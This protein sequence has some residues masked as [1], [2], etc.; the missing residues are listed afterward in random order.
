MYTV[1]KRQHIW[2][3]NTH[4]DFTKIFSNSEYAPKFYSG[5][6]MWGLFRNMAPSHS[7]QPNYIQDLR[8]KPA[9]TW[10]VAPDKKLTVQDIMSLHRYHYQNTTFDLS[11]GVGA[12]PFGSPDRYSSSTNEELFREEHQNYGNWERSIAL[13]RTTYTTIIQSDKVW[14]GPHAAHT[15]CFL[16]LS[17]GPLPPS[18]TTGDMT[19][20]D[21]K[22]AFWTFRYIH[23]LVNIRYQ[24]LHA[25]FIAPAQTHWE[26][27]AMK[28]NPTEYHTHIEQV[29]ETWWSMVDEL[30]VSYVDGFQYTTGKPLGYPMDWLQEAK[31]QDGP[32]PPTNFGLIVIQKSTSFQN[33]H[34][35]SNKKDRRLRIHNT[36]PV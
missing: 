9:Y 33:S 7:F 17:V 19:K 4:L 26:T 18:I 32:P 10:S 15:T 31:F 1:A 13:F 35:A 6:H 24:D 14:L 20:L 8:L 25:K 28:L 34:Q 11:T 29:L 12:G 3:P 21:K 30:V 16:P 27:K 22:T 36:I 2:V 5:R 23:T